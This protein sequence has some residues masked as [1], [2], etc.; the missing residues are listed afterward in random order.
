MEIIVCIKQVPGTSEVEMDEHGN[1]IRD[2]TNTKMNPFDLFAIETALRIRESNKEKDIPTEISV[3]SMGPPQAKSVIREAFM[4][5]VDEGYLLSDRKFA[6]SDVWATAY[7]LAQ[8][9]KKIGIPDIIICGKQTTDGDTAQVGAELAEFLSLPHLTNILKIDH[10]AKNSIQVEADLPSEVQVAD[11]QFPCLIGVDKDIFTP[12][13]PSYKRKI[14][15]KDRKIKVFSFEDL[16]D[17]NV[18]HYGMEGS[19]TK[20]KKVF[21]PES[22]ND[23]VMWKG[24]AE[25]LGEKLFQKLVQDKFI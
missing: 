7:T 21:L 1:L 13:L 17:N 14:K 20:V 16:Q 8:G 18:F 22:K 10:V 15:T 2:P 3:I 24:E 12:R 23:K 6:G 11:I 19:P 25:K 5:G 9:I 4:M